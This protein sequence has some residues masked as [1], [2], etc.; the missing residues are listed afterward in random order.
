[1]V[2]AVVAFVWVVQARPYFSTA[3][4]DQQSQA[5]AGKITYSDRVLNAL[6]LN[7]E[8]FEAQRRLK[9]KA[10]L[11]D[12]MNQLQVQ[13]VDSPQY[14]GRSTVEMQGTKSRRQL[15]KLLKIYRDFLHLE[16]QQDN[17]LKHALHI[18]KGLYAIYRK[19]YYKCLKVYYRNHSLS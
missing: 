17:R 3:L 16:Q 14:S 18:Y 8:T 5:Q 4:L 19:L 9:T 12:I 10:N 13:T 1:M 11:D 6:N 15:I 7:I 2:F